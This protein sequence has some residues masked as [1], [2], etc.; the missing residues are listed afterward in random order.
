ME[1][2]CGRGECVAHSLTAKHCISLVIKHSLYV[3]KINWNTKFF[4]NEYMSPLI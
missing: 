1:V 4:H 2:G 3:L